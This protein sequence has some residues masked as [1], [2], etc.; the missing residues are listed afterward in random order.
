MKIR[1]K[2]G[3][4]LAFF[5][6]MAAFLGGGC[7]KGPASSPQPRSTFGDRSS[8]D[9]SLRQPKMKRAKGKKAK[10]AGTTNPYVEDSKRR[11]QRMQRDQ[12]RPQY[13]DPMYFGHKKPPKKRKRGKQKYCKECGMKH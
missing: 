4:R 6:L 13:T 5:L 1:K 3:I 10:V 8:G 7:A 12:D 2:H 11:Y 9:A